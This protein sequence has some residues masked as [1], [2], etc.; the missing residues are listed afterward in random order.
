MVAAV[1]LMQGFMF[2]QS[3]LQRCVM[4]CQ[5]DIKD[6]VATDTTE[7]QVSFEWIVDTNNSSLFF[8]V[9][10]MK[11]KL[12]SRSKRSNFVVE[13]IKLSLFHQT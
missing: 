9:F 1:I 2:R 6:K 13:V 3:R 8:T 7:A 4:V 11:W 5:D 12:S 10:N